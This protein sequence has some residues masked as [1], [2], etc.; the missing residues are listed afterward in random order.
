MIR[1]LNEVVRTTKRRVELVTKDPVLLSFLGDGGD[2]HFLAKEPEK[3]IRRTSGGNNT[4]WTVAGDVVTLTDQFAAE[5][6]CQI[7]LSVLVDAIKK[8]DEQRRYNS[9]W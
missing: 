6:T 4:H 2:W 3:E 5:N 7:K 9:S 8:M 1:R